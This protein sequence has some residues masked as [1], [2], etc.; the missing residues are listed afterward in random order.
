MKPLS[1]GRVRRRVAVVALAWLVLAPAVALA[2]D[3][4]AASESDPGA[5]TSGETGGERVACS[6][7]AEVFELLCKSFE[8]L[9]DEYVDEP[10]PEDLAQAAAAA[11]REAALA[12]RGAEAAPPCAVPEPAFEQTC[13]EIDQVHDTAAAVWAASVAMFE[14]L[15][16]HNTFLAS[17][18]E[19]TEMQQRLEAGAAYSGI[20]LRL[21]LLEGT[22]ACDELSETCRLV[23]SE[24]FPGSPAEQ[25][26]LQADDIVL[27]LAG[28]VPSGSG[29]GL[30][31]LP[32]FE[33]G[34]EVPVIVERDGR[35]R[36]FTPQA[37]PLVAPSVASRTVAGNIGYLRI[38]GFA[39]GID[40][41][42]GEELDKL[43]DADVDSLVI[44]VR[45]NPG[46]Y[47]HTVINT[48]SLFLEDRLL[49]IREV[50]R[51]ETVRHLV[52]DRDGRSRPVTL[53]V[54][55]AVDEQS[56]SGSELLALALRDHERATLIG[57][58][59]YGKN[60][61]QI[62][63]PIESESGALLGGARVTVFRW[64]GPSRSSSEGGVT[65]DAEVEHPH[66]AHATAVARRVAAAA[67]A[68]TLPADVELEG[69]TSESLLALA[70]DGILDRTECAPGLFCGDEAIPRWLTAVWLVRVL[71][72]Q[73]P[74]P[75]SSSR[76]SDVAAEAWWAAHAD[77]LADLGVTS[78]CAAEPARFCPEDAVSRA[79][80]ASFLTR[81]FQLEAASP[82]GFTDTQGSVHAADID[83]L[84]AA[85]VT[86]GCSAD[87]LQFCGDRATSRAQ[88]AV[89]LQRAR[90]R[91]S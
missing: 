90:N 42:V 22:V 89:F 67:F 21:G 36:P 80:M 78:G 30:E 1:G 62:T 49:V 86:L 35:R 7:A 65:P 82:T 66:C 73:D 64:L 23:V 69:E 19:H 84:A 6:E 24:V 58:T 12:P 4:G 11:V 45:G 54:A 59:T 85:G 5:E 37:A 25:V 87:P 74:E 31:D 77:R 16:D 51:T 46:G 48:A 28:I 81:A 56:A 43:A 17:P 72:G 39:Q 27:R 32:A 3:D 57:T 68:G 33:P 75:I 50:S 34:T 83:A 13:V 60:T 70:S 55:M 15:G 18:S 53:P 44:D 26:G 88:M 76:F 14:S 2:Q 38:E 8:L 20:G 79:Q 61:G 47:L 91:T 40:H 10:A 52:S 63:V 71:D 9:T 41:L 29:C